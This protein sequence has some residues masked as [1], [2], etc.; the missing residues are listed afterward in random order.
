MQGAAF[1]LRAGS[2][3]CGLLRFGQQCADVRGGGVEM[4]PAEGQCLPAVAVG[5]QSEVANLDE[6]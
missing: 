6:A 3:E 1:A 2:T 4:E 5:E